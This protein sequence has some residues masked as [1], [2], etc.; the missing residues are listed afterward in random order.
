MANQDIGGIL[1]LNHALWKHGQIW[2]NDHFNQ[3]G[4]EEGKAGRWLNI[5]NI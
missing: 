5:F 2:G 3:A 4:G 1:L